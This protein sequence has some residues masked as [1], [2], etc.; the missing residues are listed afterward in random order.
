[1]IFFLFTFNC[2]Q[3][4]TAQQRG[5]QGHGGVCVNR[6]SRGRSRD[7]A[8]RGEYGELEDIVADDSPS[9]SAA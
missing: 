2:P 3:S 7:E 5:C 9:L 8:Q 1:M 6:G 4:W